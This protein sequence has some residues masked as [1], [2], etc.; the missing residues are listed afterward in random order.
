MKV[1]YESN[2]WIEIKKDI[3]GDYIITTQTVDGDMVEIFTHN[4]KHIKEFIKQINKI[5]D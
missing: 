4:Q 1:T 2:Y 5:N 3:D